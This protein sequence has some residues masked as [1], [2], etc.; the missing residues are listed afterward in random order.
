MRAQAMAASHPACPA[1]TTTTSY[2]SVN[3]ICY[4]YLIFP[5]STHP[6]Y[7]SINISMKFT[8]WVFL[9]AGVWGI[10]VLA[11]LY[12]LEQFV[13]AQHQPAITHPEYFY[14]FIGVALAWQILFLIIASDPI[15]YRGV[16]PASVI[17]KFAFVLAVYALLAKQ[18]V[19]ASM[20]V[21]ATIDLL[22]G[23][24]F[25]AAFVK[26]SPADPSPQP[27]KRNLR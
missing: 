4:Q 22:L 13:G 24:L 12:F 2:C 23:I 21:A 11:P 1:P 7:S 25:I 19:D 26:A 8:R 3:D 9:L 27:E 15:R 6:A 5:E 20:A 17:E 14:G 16:M 18:R 10:V